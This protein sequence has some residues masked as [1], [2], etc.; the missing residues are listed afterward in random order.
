MEHHDLLIRE[1]VKHSVPFTRTSDFD[2]LIDRIKD[3]KI[4]MLGESSHG[5][6]EFYEWRTK[7]TEELI[8]KHGFSFIAVEGDWPP[9]Q[10]VNDFIQNKTEKSAGEVLSNFSRWPTWMWANQ[11][12]LDLMEWLQ[13]WNRSSETPVGFHG[14]DVYSLY[15]SMDEIKETLSEIDPRLAREVDKLYSCFHPY[16]NNEKAYAR[17]LFQHPA[18]CEK[19]V[20]KALEKILHKT[21]EH[22]DQFFD[23]AQNARIIRNA[24]KYY[25]AMINGADSWNIRDRHMME[26]LSQLLEHYGTGSKCIIWEHNTHIGDYHGTDM[27]INGQ[28]CLGGLAREIIGAENV[29]LVG[30]TTY[31]GEVTASQTWEGPIEVLSVPKAKA[32]SIEHAL[33]DAIPYVGH[34]NFYVNLDHVEDYSPFLDYRGHRAIGVVY[35]PNVEQ[36]SNYVPTKLA[37]RYDALVFINQTEALRP[38]DIEFDD[39]KI[40][41]TFPF[42]SRL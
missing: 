27:L 7:I 42:G 23:V 18:G 41:E 8:K 10:K 6:H 36:K 29:S 40:P 19:E 25:H 20:S 26:T 30:F 21:L 37:R 14:L 1:I 12:M 9:C 16:W 5:T 33:H 32:G 34:E 35:H 31:S 22:R 2:P 11:E 38:L 15:D 3:K 13:D 4:V 28:V 24:E 17:S 39:K